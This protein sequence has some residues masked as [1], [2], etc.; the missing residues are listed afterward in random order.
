MDVLGRLYVIEH[1][2]MALKQSSIDE[3]Y[4]AYI[5]DA[6]RSIANNTAGDARMVMKESFRNL[7]AP[8]TDEKAD[9]RKAEEIINK[10][11]QKLKGG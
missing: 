2:V 7:I 9:E 10:I 3:A 4:R 11:K 5:T 1:V 6:L 8:K